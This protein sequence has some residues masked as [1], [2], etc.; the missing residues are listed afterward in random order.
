MNK[1]NPREN[2]AV[3]FRGGKPPKISSMRQKAHRFLDKLCNVSVGK[4]QTIRGIAVVITTR[5]DS[6]NDRAR[7]DTVYEEDVELAGALDLAALK[8]KL[9]AI[10]RSG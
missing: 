8:L 3:I 6:G 2:T 1:P 4:N 7:W 5:D 9:D 10:Q